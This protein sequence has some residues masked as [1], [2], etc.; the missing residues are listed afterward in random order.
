MGFLDKLLGRDKKAG[1]DKASDESMKSEGMHQG[2][3]EDRT[4]AAEG[5]ASHEEAP[6]PPAQS[7]N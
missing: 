6:Q 4:S 2:M 1:G 7:D 3:A 5:S